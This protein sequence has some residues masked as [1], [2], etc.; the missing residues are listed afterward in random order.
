MA[1]QGKATGQIEKIPTALAR[2]D[3][4]GEDWDKAEAQT[5]QGAGRMAAGAW[6]EATAAVMLAALGADGSKGPRNVESEE[7]IGGSDGD[8]TMDETL[9]AQTMRRIIVTDILATDHPS[10]EYMLQLATSMAEHL[11]HWVEAVRIRP[12]FP[13][14]EP[15]P[16]G[17]GSNTQKD[18]GDDSIPDPRADIIVMRDRQ[19][20]EAA[21]M[22]RRCLGRL[23]GILRSSK[24][25]NE[26]DSGSEALRKM[27]RNQ[28]MLRLGEEAIGAVALSSLQSRHRAEWCDAG[29]YQDGVF[30]DIWEENKLGEDDC[31]LGEITRPWRENAG[32][33]SFF[34][35][36]KDLCVPCSTRVEG[37]NRRGGGGFG[38]SRA[39]TFQDLDRC[40]QRL[41]LDSYSGNTLCLGGA[42]AFPPFEVPG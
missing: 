30:T 28:A 15:L 3:R 40:R 8:V 19:G 2:F 11:K 35:E 32:C 33:D 31:G 17:Q 14:V 10:P 22:V 4:A 12:P 21:D 29:W 9:D 38:R 23:S 7:V 34:D 24:D 25:E 1:R 5:Q 42:F 27:D 16:P 37:G 18:N 36:A 39:A 20:V 26:D 41:P 13:V 6:D